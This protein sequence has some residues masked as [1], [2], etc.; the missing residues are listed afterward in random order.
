MPVSAQIA[1]EEPP[2]FQLD[3]DFPVDRFGF[4]VL[5]AGTGDAGQVVTVVVWR[6]GVEVLR[7]ELAAPGDGAVF[8]GLRFDAPVDQVRVIA[9]VTGDGFGL[10]DLWFPPRQCLDLD[11]DGVTPFGGDCDDA[12][13]RRAPSLPE[14]C[15]AIDNDC[16]DDL[17][18]REGDIDRDGWL[19]C[20][21]PD[22]DGVAAA[23]GDCD[24]HDPHRFPGAVEICDG[25]DNACAGRVQSRELDL[26]RDGWL[27]CEDPDQDGVAE[28]DG[29][30]EPHDPTVYPGAA[31]LCDGQDN[32]CDGVTPERE[33]NTDRDA[34][35]A[36]EDP[37]G[38]G[39]TEADG[40]CRP[41]D[42][43]V[44]AGAPELCDGK[45]NDCDGAV[46]EREHDR[47]RDAFFACEDPDGDGV[48][49]ADGDCRPHD[50]T[51]FLGAPELC[52]G[53]DN[54]CDG[55]V[56]ANEADDDLDGYRICEGDC[57]DSDPVAHPLATEGEN[58]FDDNCDGQASGG[59]VGCGVALGG[60]TREGVIFGLVVL[61]ACLLRRWVLR[62]W[63]LLIGA[64]VGLAVVGVRGAGSGNPFAV[65]GT[66]GYQREL[67][68]TDHGTEVALLLAEE[69]IERLIV[70]LLIERGWL[71]YSLDDVEHCFLPNRCIHFD[72]DIWVEDVEVTLLAGE[73]ARLTLHLN[74]SVRDDAAGL[75]AA[76]VGGQITVDFGLAVQ[77]A[78]GQ[79]LRVG[80]T[81]GAP[82]ATGVTFTGLLGA[83]QFLGAARGQLQQRVTGLLVAL[84]PIPLQ[85]VVCNNPI[86]DSEPVRN[87]KLRTVPA[88]E[89][90]NGHAFALL[91]F[92]V[93]GLPLCHPGEDRLA[94][95]PGAFE[96]FSGNLIAPG[97]EL[98]MSFSPRVMRGMIW[99]QS[100]AREVDPQTLA[101]AR[102]S[103]SASCQP[104]DNATMLDLLEAGRCTLADKLG[105][106]NK[107]V[108]AGWDGFRD[109][110][111][112]ADPAVLGCDGVADGSFVIKEGPL[113]H[114]HFRIVAGISGKKKVLFLTASVKL[115]LSADLRLYP[116]LSDPTTPTMGV[117]IFH[118]VEKEASCLA[119]CA[120]CNGDLDKT[121][122]VFEEAGASMAGELGALPQLRFNL[123]E[124][125]G[126]FA[127]F[128]VF[129]GRPAALVF[130]GKLTTVQLGPLTAP[131]SGPPEGTIMV[132]VG[133][134]ADAVS[135]D[136]YD[137]TLRAC[138]PGWLS[139]TFR[140]GDARW[141]V[142][143]VVQE[144]DEV[145]PLPAGAWC[146]LAIAD[147][148]ATSLDT[149]PQPKV[150]VDADREDC[151]ID[152]D[153]GPD[154]LCDQGICVALPA[155]PCGSTVDCAHDEV[156][157]SRV[158]PSR[159]QGHDP[160][161]SCPDGFDVL[162]IWANRGYAE[163]L[164]TPIGP[165]SRFNPGLV[166]R[167]EP[168]VVRAEAEL[169]TCIKKEGALD[170]RLAGRV[171]YGGGVVGLSAA[172]PL[173]CAEDQRVVRAKALKL[174]PVFS[175]RNVS[176][177]V[178]PADLGTLKYCTT[179][180]FGPDLDADGL[181][182]E[183]EAEEGTDLESYSTSGDV[184]PDGV[185]ARLGLDC[186]TVDSDG[187]QLTDFM[188]IYVLGTDP[189]S[190]DTDGD[191]VPDDYEILV[192]G[193]DEVRMVGM[194]PLDAD[195]DDDGQSDG[196][197]E[198]LA[199]VL[200]GDGGGA[201]DDGDG[202]PNGYER[203]VTRTDPA[204]AD[205]DGDG[206][207]DRAEAID[208][209]WYAGAGPQV[210]D[211]EPAA[212]GEVMDGE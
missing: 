20:E 141:F 74:G 174:P 117:E 46:P 125:E 154:R 177:V 166:A 199:D 124:E 26:D 76:E 79:N 41:Q 25:L 88:A 10:D 140:L 56:P 8:V 50:P 36:C 156:C 44:Y 168:A 212:D 40:D 113:D 150:C 27:A 71:S 203:W 148:L 1:S 121:R 104:P 204:V 83:P 167:P 42:P 161:V 170:P 162:P 31:E 151:S 105:N 18:E 45:D 210:G 7:L 9:P 102:D 111:P 116:D 160:R 86:D 97:R 2:W 94:F 22:G 84:P 73:R 101:E 205:T 132:E 91:G 33:H 59:T 13:A 185:C 193:F 196:D 87:V 186:T 175:W 119:S 23:D 131:K 195:S 80:L 48:T 16:T 14:V 122:A 19:E 126:R 95:K 173:P 67:A 128:D 70:D 157:A 209:P 112:V 15:D 142:C 12:D 179:Q 191:G 171:M 39:M 43:T 106:G 190:P 194:N 99:R 62:R 64:F 127:S 32:D 92:D 180:G 115:M 69:P 34:W 176:P 98:A 110:E 136:G 4:W 201:D 3:F 78:C 137:P 149:Q 118:R 58:G 5:D 57:A 107:R 181:C 24:P 183:D 159:C 165:A 184:L 108:A 28:A 208:A 100:F 198:L 197:E 55:V 153:C 21:D 169:V 82:D 145:L 138:P 60:R 53:L 135:V 81:A 200:P 35:R 134:R 130:S 65:L 178:L 202:L 75:P 29:D 6:G 146:G 123:G 17:P 147:R 63:T 152:A 206:R 66:P 144:A 37:D 182:V 47:D 172:T 188:E 49:E 120:D 51:I 77:G 163:A 85:N 11:L 192:V 103:V 158:P 207:S 114:P 133:E 164:A 96:R 211:A 38:D 54:D 89:S 155:V 52:D 93:L 139:R 30:C 187:D 72:V 189:L 61:L 90:S 143:E 68:L 129:E 109:A